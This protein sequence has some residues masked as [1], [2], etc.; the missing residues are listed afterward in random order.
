MLLAISRIALG[1]I[2]LFMLMAILPAAQPIHTTLFKSAF[3]CWLI[4]VFCLPLH[5]L[6][7]GKSEAARFH[8]NREKEPVRFWLGFVTCTLLL[9]AGTAW[10]IFLAW[11]RET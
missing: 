3:C 10:F 7:T 4:I 6:I 2:M 1:L 11:L 5:W 8:A 9:Y